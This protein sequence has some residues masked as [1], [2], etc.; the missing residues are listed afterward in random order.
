MHQ[1]VDKG[2][3]DIVR[4][5]VCDYGCDVMAR[6]SDG[7]TPLHL[8]ARNG[9]LSAV[10]MLIDEFK[11]D[12]NAKGWKGRTPVHQ[13]ALNGHTDTVLKL[14]HDYGCDVIAKDDDGNTFLHH[15]AFGGSLSAVCTLIDEFKCD[16]N[17]KG[18]KGRI[19]LHHAARKGHIDIV[20]KL[21]RDYGCDVNTVDKDGHNPMYFAHRADMVTEL[22]KYN[23]DPGAV[24]RNYKKVKKSLRD[25]V[26][27]HVLVVGHPGAGK[28]TLVE[29]LK[30]DTW[31]S[32]QVANVP[33]HIAGIIPHICQDKRYD[34]IIFHDFAGH[35]Q[36]YSSHAAIL[37]WI[38]NPGCHIVIV[39]VDLSTG[40]KAETEAIL[41]WLTFISYATKGEAKVIIAGS[42]ADLLPARDPEE[43]LS[44]LHTKVSSTLHTELSTANLEIVGYVAL[45]CRYTKSEPLHKL[46]V[47]IKSC[48]KI[49][50]KLSPG[51][52]ILHHILRLMGDLACVVSK[53]FKDIHYKMYYESYLTD[54]VQN[55][56]SWAK[57][58]ESHG[59]VLVL[60][61]NSNPSDTW[62]VT[63]LKMFMNTV[64]EG[65]FSEKA[66]T[67]RGPSS[68][69]GLIPIP[70]LSVLFPHL[71]PSVLVSCLELLQYCFKMDD[72]NILIQELRAKQNSSISDRT[73]YTSSS[74]LYWK[75]KQHG[76][77]VKVMCV[78]WDGTLAVR[79][80]V[81]S[82]LLGLPMS[83]C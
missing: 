22:I 42:H 38:A 23:C 82:F 64:H 10:C 70:Q 9:S 58:L 8:A 54:D 75:Q 56:L 55:I 13:A 12:R 80:S 50:M 60:Q 32:K 3:I 77:C 57:E 25:T 15:S 17:T 33:P 37:E 27:G 4:K 74:Q 61:N 36:F 24:I 6:D 68:N 41:F 49:K 76:L 30:S 71:P 72:H 16:P 11:C 81:P 69:L 7:D 78:H 79:D 52:V 14:V 34:R 39:V 18:Y 2:H 63:D 83:C 28:S 73:E 46:H 45:D 59:Y 47:F 51:A 35:P 40:T 21:V 19:P 31:F 44:Q 62:I 66:N 29:A 5:L 26:S 20:R 48:V 65:L 53:I 1:A 43:E 67:K